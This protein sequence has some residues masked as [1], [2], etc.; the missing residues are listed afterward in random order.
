V[1]PVPPKDLIPVPK[2]EI[3]II[4]PNPIAMIEKG[5]SSRETT[6]T[7]RAENSNLNFSLKN[8]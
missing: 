7:M 5:D 2:K 1:I 8:V 3:A 6:D 4:Q